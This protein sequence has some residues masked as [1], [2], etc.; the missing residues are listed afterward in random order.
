MTISILSYAQS[1]CDILIK[2]GKII[3]GTG[4]SWY[5]GDI[6]ISNGKIAGIGKN[7]TLMAGKIIQAQGLIVAPGFIDVHTHIE[8]DE[9]EN[10]TADNF[11]YDGVTTV[12]AGNCGASNV[13]IGKYL[14]WIDTFRLS[15]NVASLI[16]HNDIRK[17]VMGRANRDASP[18]ELI[19][20][21]Q[22]VE[23]AML[24]GSL[25]LSTGLIYIPGTYT[26]TA[27]IIALAKVASRHNG[28]YAT[29]MRDEGDRVTEAIHEALTIGR[30][31][32]LPVE[33]SH[34]KVS[35]QQNWGR[36]KETL[37]MIENARKEGLDVTID[38]YPYTASSTSIST[39]LPDE[40][41][42][43]GQDS[44][45]ARLQNKEI[46]NQVILSMLK[47]LKKRKLKHFSYAVVAN[48]AP[49]T[50]FNGKS[51]EAINLMMGRKHKARQE[52]ETI[53]DIM[54]KGGAGAVFHGMGDQDVKHIM[55]YPFNMFASDA[56]IRIFNQG[57]PHPRGYGTN[58]R[59]LGKYVRDEKT[60]SLEEAIRR[61]SSLPA[62][63][64]H[65]KDRG[66]L[67]EGMAA[68]IVLFD[69][70]AVKDMATYQKPHAYSK[71][72]HYV[73]VNGH[74]TLE[75]EKHTGV[76]AGIALYGNR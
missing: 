54:L 44:I 46:K 48:F 28:V 26:K 34:F 51:I 56:S 73:L 63:K 23:Q 60:I 29:H 70:A 36:S 47:R 30:E 53:I 41:L 76:R 39:L 19:K 66:L 72:F 55:K 27:E 25:G 2:N 65:L 74:I 7:L 4:N 50:S 1:S 57:V 5:Y 33:I 43:D 21:E 58:A 8:G 18:D 52:A 67:K 62:Q 69:E 59:V 9:K 14:H 32:N 17:A 35:G 45:K 75:N 22:L 31:A 10:P 64:F 71:G 49:D 12:I 40:V 42:A 3:D 68:D 24:D 20:M 15:V 37:A 38:Q 11:I 13:Y 6:A 61:M 16:G